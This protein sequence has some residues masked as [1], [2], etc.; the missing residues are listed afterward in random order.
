MI[1]PGNI[2]DSD[3]IIKTVRDS[4]QVLQFNYDGKKLL[5]E[6]CNSAYENT[7]HYLSQDLLQGTLKYWGEQNIELIFL[8]VQG[9]LLSGYVL[10]MILP[11]NIP[12]AI[13]DS[14][15]GEYYLIDE[16]NEIGEF[17]AVA[18]PKSYW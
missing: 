5:I 17:K 15:R 18:K 6:S 14:L 2:F 1:F 11:L 10:S 3:D 12:I 4:N 13:Y 8:K 16:R 7:H 9:E